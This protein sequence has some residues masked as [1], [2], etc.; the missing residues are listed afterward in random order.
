MPWTLDTYSLNFVD[1]VSSKLNQTRINHSFYSLDKAIQRTQKDHKSNFSKSKSLQSILR[2][3][4][5]RESTSKSKSKRLP[6][7]ASETIRTRMKS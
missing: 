3:S 2:E 5:I 7:F 1:Y 4:K 6:V